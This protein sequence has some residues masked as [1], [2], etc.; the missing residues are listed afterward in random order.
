MLLFPIYVIHL[1]YF[2]HA[3][4]GYHVIYIPG[5]VVAKSSLLMALKPD[6]FRGGGKRDSMVK[7]L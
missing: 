5:A 2:S 7:L 4:N 1:Q 6:C 3:E